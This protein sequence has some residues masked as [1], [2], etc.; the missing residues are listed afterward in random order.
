MLIAR[1]VCHSSDF[2]L[3]APSPEI[4]PGAGVGEYG[5]SSDG[6]MRGPQAED[7]DLAV[8]ARAGSGGE[9]RATACP[10]S[11][12]AAAPGATRG[13]SLL[14]LSGTRASAGWEGWGGER[15]FWKAIK[16]S[17]KCR[18]TGKTVWIKILPLTIM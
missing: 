7:P 11:G 6:L 4:V 15:C 9:R 14:P 2:V 1:P 13:M 8:T 16:W 12:E 10:H 3:T 18:N 5:V 17:G